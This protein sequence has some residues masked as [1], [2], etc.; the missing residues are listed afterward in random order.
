M[1]ISPTKRLDDIGEYFFSKKLREIAQLKSNGADIINLG[2]GSPDMAPPDEAIKSMIETIN[3]PTSH[4]YQSYKGSEELR[5]GFSEWYQQYYQV[6]LNPNTEILPLLG[7]KEG[8]LQISLAFLNEGDFVLIPNPSYPTYASATKLSGATIKYYNLDSE[9]SWL[10]NLKELESE[11]L[12][13][14]KIMWVN[15]PNMPTGAHA[16]KEFFEKLIEFGIKHQ[17][18]ICNDNPY[19]FI[20]NTNYLSIL[21]IDGAKEIALELN[22]LSKSHNLSGWRV[23]MIAGDATYIDHI[24]RM[25]SNIDSGMFLGIQKGAISALKSTKNWFERIN[26]EYTKRRNY[27]Y[28]ILDHFE[29]EY[30]KKQAGLFIW[31]K[32]PRNFVNEESFSDFLLYKLHIFATPGIVFGG[33]GDQYIRFSLCAGINELEIALHRVKSPEK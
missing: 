19:S 8:I 6:D 5:S 3:L 12:S 10:P 30:D 18:L 21:S 31:S 23:G 24:L 25:K 4:A 7:S 15:Y 2:I 32:I 13:K 29:C 16:T 33:N 20:L 26:N 17:I 1:K 11:D 28:K 14:V 22:S 27:I 9:N